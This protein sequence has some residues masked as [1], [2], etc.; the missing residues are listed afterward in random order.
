MHNTCIWFIERINQTCKH[1]RK[2]E[3]H[4]VL[5]T[6][7]QSIREATMV[8]SFPKRRIRTTNIMI[9]WKKIEKQYMQ[10]ICTYLHE[11]YATYCSFGSV[12]LP[13][14]S[15]LTSIGNPKIDILHFMKRLKTVNVLSLSYELGCFSIDA[16]G[17]KVWTLLPLS[18]QKLI[19][20][21]H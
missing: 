9:W 12:L 21:S 11:T 7:I 14:I 2:H 16:L 1:Q 8:V 19:P 6:T 4:S 5:G 3:K 10:W 17:T 20:V 13:I 15:Y 18:Y